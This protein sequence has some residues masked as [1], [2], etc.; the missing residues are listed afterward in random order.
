ML[1]IRFL[2]NMHIARKISERNYSRLCSESTVLPVL[3]TSFKDSG[4]TRFYLDS[5]NIYF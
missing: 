3:P 4:L 1:K 5:Y 2:V